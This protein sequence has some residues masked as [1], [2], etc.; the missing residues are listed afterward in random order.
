MLFFFKVY[1]T[2]VL[3]LQLAKYSMRRGMRD[4]L[5]KRK[6]E[7]QAKTMEM[8]GMQEKGGRMLKTPAT[9]RTVKMLE[10]GT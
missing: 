1:F 7:A 4:R 2:T 8:E 10:T 6:K 9:Y 5:R 3:I